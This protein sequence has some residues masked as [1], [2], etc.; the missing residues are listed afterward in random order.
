VCCGKKRDPSKKPERN[1]VEEKLKK[2][3]EGWGEKKK[4]STKYYE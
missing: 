4:K 2:P 1:V 3:I